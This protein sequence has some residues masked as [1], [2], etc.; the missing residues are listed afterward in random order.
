MNTGMLL[1]RGGRRRDFLAESL[2]QMKHSAK[3]GKA[4]VGLRQAGMENGKIR[5]M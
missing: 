4:D 5:Q 2:L 3:S 1:F